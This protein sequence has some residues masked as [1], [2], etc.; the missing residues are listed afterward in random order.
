[1][2]VLTMKRIAETAKT[3]RFPNVVVY[4]TN[5]AHLRKC[6]RE[7]LKCGE[8]SKIMKTS[9]G[10]CPT[11]TALPSLGAVVGAAPDQ[12]PQSRYISI[13]N[14]TKNSD[15]QRQSPHP[16]LPRITEVLTT[17]L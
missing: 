14:C 11:D 8:D 9:L 3:G 1:M 12:T 17:I 16:L 10:R 13:R 15:S 4:V 7:F 5:E 6:L 2:F